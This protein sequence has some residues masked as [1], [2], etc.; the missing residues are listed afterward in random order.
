MTIKTHW[1]KEGEDDIII[2]NTENLSKKEL[3]EL[4][5]IY[6]SLLTPKEIEEMERIIYDRK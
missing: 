1:L 6:K 5:K 2:E 3:K 4:I